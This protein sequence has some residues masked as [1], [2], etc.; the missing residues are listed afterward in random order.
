MFVNNIIRLEVY[1][2]FNSNSESLITE[3]FFS[4]GSRT[5]SR[6]LRDSSLPSPRRS[7]QLTIVITYANLFFITV[8]IT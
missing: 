7:K 3:V 2:H 5:F 4:S 8:G 6:Y 1:L